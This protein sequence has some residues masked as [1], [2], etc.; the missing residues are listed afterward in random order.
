M[1]RIPHLDASNGAWSCTWS[2]RGGSVIT[3]RCCVQR[4]WKRCKKKKVSEKLTVA[5]EQLDKKTRFPKNENP[6][7]AHATSTSN[8]HSIHYLPTNFTEK[9]AYSNFITD[10]LLLRELETDGDLVMRKERLGTSLE[11]V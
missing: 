7:V 2:T 4:K 9:C 5:L 11:T 3:M 6:N 1:N 8:P 10:E